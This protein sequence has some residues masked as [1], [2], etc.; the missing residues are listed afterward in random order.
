VV[1]L[2]SAVEKSV[3]IVSESTLIDPCDPSFASTSDLCSVLLSNLSGISANNSESPSQPIHPSLQ[4]NPSSTAH[5]RWRSSF[6]SPVCK[7]VVCVRLHRAICTKVVPKHSGTCNDTV[8]IANSNNPLS[9]CTRAGSSNKRKD[10]SAHGASPEGSSSRR[11]ASKE[12]LKQ[13]R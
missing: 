2:I 13:A 10:K 9:E 12:R 6:H 8:M 3:Q 11:K 5:G 1:I 4:E 7:E